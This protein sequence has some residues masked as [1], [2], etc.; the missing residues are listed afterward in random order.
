MR[1]TFDFRFFLLQWAQSSAEGKDAHLGHIRLSSR[2]NG[3][4]IMGSKLLTGGS[5]PK[6]PSRAQHSTPSGG[7]N[8]NNEADG[9][10]ALQP[11]AGL[12]KPAS[13]PS[14]PPFPPRPPRRLASPLPVQLL[15]V[16]PVSGSK[17]AL[18][19]VWQL[20]KLVVN[21]CDWGGSSRG[22]RYFDSS[23]VLL[24]YCDARV[25]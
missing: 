4:S 9:L 10:L 19:G 21:Y 8:P 11:H 25:V 17:M 1:Y 24:V 7:L 6:Q 3:S 2:K 15:W 18:R 22:I 20:Q 12:P 14:P 13:S 16:G 5:R 23:I